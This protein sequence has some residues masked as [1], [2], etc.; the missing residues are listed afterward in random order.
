MCYFPFQYTLLLIKSELDKCDFLN[1][2]K[3]N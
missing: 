2:V 1:L 3:D